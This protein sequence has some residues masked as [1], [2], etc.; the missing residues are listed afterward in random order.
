[1]TYQEMNE[2]GSAF[3][4]MPGNVFENISN[5]GRLVGLKNH[6]IEYLINIINRKNVITKEGEE[7]E[8]MF[9]KIQ[10]YFNSWKDKNVNN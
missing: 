6:E 10:G 4:K 3:Q 1:M 7:L 2:I 5:H 8:E 9:Q